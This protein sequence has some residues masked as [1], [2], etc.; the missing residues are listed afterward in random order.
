MNTVRV[1]ASIT[2][3][4]WIFV[5][6]TIQFVKIFPLRFQIEE[7]FGSLVLITAITLQLL[8]KRPVIDAVSF[9]TWILSILK[10]S[11]P[12]QKLPFYPENKS[13]SIKRIF[14]RKENSINTPLSCVRGRRVVNFYS[15]YVPT[16][17]LVL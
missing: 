13:V 1:A 12:L 15:Q 7:R 14:G 3:Q 4:V 16:F 5:K 2:G 10:V 8:H 11:H 17:P 9:R 6:K